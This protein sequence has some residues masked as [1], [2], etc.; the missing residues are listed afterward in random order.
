MW[1]NIVIILLSFVVEAHFKELVV[2]HIGDRLDSLDQFVEN[3]VDILFD[4]V[5]HRTK[6]GKFGHHASSHR[7]SLRRFLGVPRPTL[8]DCTTFGPQVHW[9]GS[10]PQFCIESMPRRHNVLETAFELERLPKRE[11]GKG[12]L[13]QGD[14]TT[15]ASSSAIDLS[16]MA[17]GQAQCM[18]Q[19]CLLQIVKCTV[20]DSQC[21]AF[22]QCQ[23]DHC[24]PEVLAHAGYTKKIDMDACSA[25]CQMGTIQYPEN[26][27]FA[28][29]TACMLEHK[30][31]EVIE[32]N[33]PV[34]QEM[35]T[36]ERVPAEALV[37]WTG[38]AAVESKTH[39]DDGRVHQ[40]M[41]STLLGEFDPVQ[42]FAG[43]ELSGKTWYIT[44]GLNPLFDL[45]RNQRI[46]CTPSK[47]GSID[48]TM[49]F[50]VPEKFP[51][52]DEPT[53]KIM[54]H[55]RVK[56]QRLIPTRDNAAHLNLI[57]NLDYPAEDDWYVIGANVTGQ[58]DTDYIFVVYVGSNTA[59]KGYGGAILLTPTTKQLHPE[60]ELHLTKLAKRANIN[61]L[62]MKEPIADELVSNLG[63]QAVGR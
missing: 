15:L 55:Q 30:C 35:W 61:W 47:D 56:H 38:H 3:L 44:R 8:F 2:N 39:P 59:W 58:D 27:V 7:T 36:P 54:R 22:V 14:A 46:H 20:F 57:V 33:L 45:L 11:D 9:V 12:T 51:W 31:I 10:W 17:L 40:S 41:T 52:G 42:V 13:W 62:D 63:L 43:N 6:L 28:E 16:A 53:A 37:T 1:S 18:L 50:D 48:L 5:L 23:R 21:R 32:N 49:D 60:L 25:R 19:R 4:Q 29:L 26:K 24:T 34:S